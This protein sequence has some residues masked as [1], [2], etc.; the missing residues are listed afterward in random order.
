[1]KAFCVSV[2]AALFVVLLGVV[3][4]QVACSESL[5]GQWVECPDAGVPACSE[6]S[7]APSLP[8]GR[9]EAGLDGSPAF[10]YAT[11]R[12][13]Y[14]SSASRT[15]FSI[16]VGAISRLE[17][18]RVT[19]VVDGE[20]IG[21]SVVGRRGTRIVIDTV[22]GLCQPRKT[23]CFTAGP[24]PIHCGSVIHVRTAHGGLVASARFS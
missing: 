10:L 11:G 22:T 14:V 5:S 12:A 4:L 19:F 3:A 17:G 21:S 6:V 16:R 9:I 20:S 15:S 2:S 18:K 24:P 8:G 7:H 23:E 13:R 1:M